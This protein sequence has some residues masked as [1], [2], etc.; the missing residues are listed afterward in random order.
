MDNMENTLKSMEGIVQLTFVLPIVMTTVVIVLGLGIAM[1][2]LWLDY[3]KKRDIFALHH[4]ERMLAI[5]RGMDVPPLPLELLSGASRQARL[6]GPAHHLRRGLLWLLGGG[7][8]AVA[9]AVNR[10]L[11][12]ATW[13]LIPSAIGLAY[14]LVYSADARQRRTGGRGLIETP[15]VQ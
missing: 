10:D 9:L 13:G 6:T 1:L 5:E 3:R 4:K 8:L 7:A 15:P 12:S 14:L 2:A 11:P